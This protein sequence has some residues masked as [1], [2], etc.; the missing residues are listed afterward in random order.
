MCTLRVSL[1]H[2]AQSDELPRH[3]NDSGNNSRENH[4]M[5]SGAIHTDAETGRENHQMD[6]GA[7][8]TDADAGG[9][10][11]AACRRTGEGVQET[12][13]FTLGLVQITRP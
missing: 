6:S 12:S 4:Q 1:L 8:H 5:D 9:A 13:H 3:A 10:E 7:I 11:V 2:F